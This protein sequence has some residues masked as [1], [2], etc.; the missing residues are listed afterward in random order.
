[1]T[2]IPLLLGSPLLGFVAIIAGFCGGLGSIIGL[3][4]H[5]AFGI[6]VNMIVAVAMVHSRVGFFMNWTALFD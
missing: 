3:L 5:V 2:H 4:G 6:L 1:M